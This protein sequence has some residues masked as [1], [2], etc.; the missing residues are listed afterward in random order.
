MRV[1]REEL[2]LKELGRGLQTYRSR[3]KSQLLPI[4]DIHPFGIPFK[5]SILRKTFA[6]TAARNLSRALTAISLSDIDVVHAH[7]IF[8]DGLACAF[9]LEKQPTPLVV[10]AHGSDVHF[11]SGGVRDALAPL[12]QR[13]DKII[14][15]SHF[16]GARLA[17]FGADRG[18]IQTVP[19]G[20]PGEQFREIVTTQ[21]DQH[22]IAF[23]G[24]LDDI[25]RVDLL[26]NALTMCAENVTLDIAGDGS[27]RQQYEALAKRLNLS[28]RVTFQGRIS[29]DEVP[30]FLASAA[31]M[32]LVSR[33]EG[34]PTVIFEALACGTPVIATAVG[35]I[36]E[37]LENENLGRVV[38]ADIMPEALAQEIESALAATWDRQA[39]ID[40]AFEFTWRR[41]TD[42]LIDIY[43]PLLNDP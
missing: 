7:T 20:F 15:V 36:P 38:P 1:R 18:K 25:K 22:K 32:A 40:H 28:D 39:I 42:R 16:L 31:I 35:G 29:R 37:A 30:G 5:G 43:N 17:E 8:P 26:I 14:P 24:R 21:R 9:W 10:T 23:L 3:T 33:M 4:G 12:F 6:A 34:W 41:I 27:K 19:N 13:A 11:A 2:T